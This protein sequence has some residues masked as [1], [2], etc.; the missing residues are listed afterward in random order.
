MKSLESV[1]LEYW[2]VKL[3]TKYKYETSNPC[4]VN[5]TSTKS[6]SNS[7]CPE[8]GMSKEW[9]KPSLNLKLGD[10]TLLNSTELRSTKDDATSS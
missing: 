4:E 7:S 9:K 8:L 10:M 1:V 5:P 6:S 2:K 3:E